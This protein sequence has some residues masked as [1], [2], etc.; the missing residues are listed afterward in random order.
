MYEE[1]FGLKEKPFSLVPDPRYFYFSRGHSEALAHLLYGTKSEGGFVL[2]TGEVGTGKTM[3]CRFLVQLA[4][5]DAEV[6]LILNPKLTVEEL[7]AAVCD[8]FSISYP[9]GTMSIQVFVARLNKYLLDVHAKG[10]RAVL[11]I[12]EAQHLS[13]EVLEQIRLLTNLETNQHKLLQ[14]ILLGQPKLRDVLSQPE[15]CQFSQRITSRYHLGPL[16]KEEVPAYVEYRLSVAGPAHRRLFP[17][18]VLERLA[19]LSGGIPRLINVLCDRAL[20]GAYTQ[21]KNQVDL[22]TLVRAKSEVFGDGGSP[23]GRRSLYAGLLAGFLLILGAIL[24]ATY[25]DTHPRPPA[26][27]VVEK[28]A[29]EPTAKTETVKEAAMEPPNGSTSDST[30]ETAYRALFREWQIEYRPGDRSTVCEQAQ[31]HNLRCL[32][33]RGSM[34]T[35]RQMN[36]PVVLKLLD[37]KRAVYYATLT[38]LRGEMATCV[39]GNDTKTV[40]VNGITQQWSGEFVVL[41]RLP[42]GY[43]KS[44]KPGNSGPLVAWLDRQLAAVQ[45]RAVRGGSGQAYHGELVKQVKEFQAAAGL[46]PDGMVGPLTILFLDGTDKSGPMLQGGKAGD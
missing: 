34:R 29:V 41:W 4:L 24:A 21:R 37:E 20:L 5:E 12:E 3:A 43:R 44:L 27:G 19:R 1:Y 30:R 18:A 31:A 6:A 13:A 17:P 22:E 39:I 35:L 38:A 33:R 46:L 2:L 7:L 23:R 11:I 42:S 14:L 45:K 26:R 28:V 40:A 25:Y 36:R 32:E 15:L 16:S 9:E 10:R 8:E